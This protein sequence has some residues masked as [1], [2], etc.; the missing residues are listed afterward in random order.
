M[1]KIAPSITGCLGHLAEAPV[2]ASLGLC[3]V[4]MENTAERNAY[5]IRLT[6]SVFGHTDNTDGVFKDTIFDVLILNKELLRAWCKSSVVFQAIPGLSGMKINSFKDKL[7]NNCKSFC[8][9]YCL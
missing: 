3:Q 5:F 8:L 9:L 4:H 7:Q 1:Q 6:F 2:A